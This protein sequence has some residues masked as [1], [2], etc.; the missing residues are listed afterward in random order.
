MH[1]VRNLYYFRLAEKISLEK[2][3]A[4]NFADREV[5]DAKDQAFRSQTELRITEKQRS[6]TQIVSSSYTS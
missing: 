6:A 3:A 1:C 4:L 5:N 2:E